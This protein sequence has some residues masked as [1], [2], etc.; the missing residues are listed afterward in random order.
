MNYD[1]FRIYYGDGSTCDGSPET[2]RDCPAGWPRYGV[3][4][5]IANDAEKG[6]QSLVLLTVFNEDIYIFSTDIGW[7]GTSKYADLMTH[8][9]HGKV[10]RVLAGLWIPRV[11]FLAIQERAIHDP[12][13][14][15]KSANDPAR[16]D[17][18]Q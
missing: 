13:F 12:D 18:T 17:G 3:Q 1:N 6:N 9:E 10:E 5:I 8:L 15:R 11:N 14:N 4:Y 16:E 7:H 2:V